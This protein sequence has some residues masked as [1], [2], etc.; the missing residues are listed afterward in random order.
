[1]IQTVLVQLL[2]VRTVTATALHTVNVTLVLQETVLL[3]QTATVGRVS[4]T[5]GV[6][7]IALTIVTVTAVQI[8]SATATVLR[9][10]TATAQK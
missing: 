5:V 1:V 10:G 2:L 7:V 6:T 9:T 8:P 3:H 4:V